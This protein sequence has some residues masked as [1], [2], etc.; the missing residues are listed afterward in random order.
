M[1]TEWIADGV[2]TAV[3]GFRAAGVACGI[4]AGGALDLALVASDRP[5]AAA[6][7]FTTNRFPAAPVL[8]DRE[9]LAANPSGVR[10]V[11][12][13]AGCANACT[14][15]EGLADAR[16]MA[17]LAA[18]AAGC[19]AG[20]ALVMSTGVIGVRL[21]MERLRAGLP[22]AGQALSPEGGEAA[23]RAIMTTDTRPKACALRTVVDGRTVTVAGMAKGS[24][25]I[26]PN[27]A[28]MLA[29]VATD[30]ATTPH[31]LDAL[32]RRVTARSFNAVT[33]D[34]DTSTNDTVLLLANGAAGHAPLADPDAPA[35]R[36]LA[37]ALE[38]VAL[39]LAQAIARD[40]EGASHF[41]TIHVRGAASEADAMRAAKA[42]AHSPLVKT[43]IYGGDP[44]W[45]RVLCAVGYSGAQV[46]PARAAL[47]FGDVALVAGGR[48][49]DYDE[50]QAAAA[51]EQPDVM[52][53]VDLGL[54]AG[55]ATVWTCDLTHGY[56]D[57]NAHYRT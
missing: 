3:P 41:V 57:I 51:L 49:L 18:A 9:A 26:H 45:G 39:H 33:V 14:G 40:G 6:G 50:R 4:K 38:A 28:T 11:A 55:E 37:E 42:V 35:A 52:I 24:G 54:G 23:A 8:Y 46:D 30:A 29:L 17:A 1:S 25:M 10:V 56:V 7:V 47:W 13:N 53:T 16:E 43:A 36:P 34:G 21:P 20:S 2:L 15:E 5:C 48:P 19:P 22:L 44:N 12:I 32:L 31:V 27:M